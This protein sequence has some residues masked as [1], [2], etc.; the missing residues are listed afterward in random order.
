M[1]TDLHTHTTASDG[2]LTPTELLEAA[3]END[4]S[5]L[6]IT[7]HDTLSGYR[8]AVEQDVPSDLR[9]IPGI[10]LSTRWHTIGVHVL[11]LDVG[12]AS[13]AMRTAEQYQQNARRERAMR[14][15]RRLDKLTVPNLF[16]R[17]A[18]LAG[19]AQIG[20]PH[21]A[22]ILVAEGVVKDAKAA[23]AKYLGAGKLGDIRNGWADLSTV[24]TWIRASGGVA[25]L[26]HPARYGLT[27][28]RLAALIADFA[29]VGGNAIEVLSGAQDPTT[30]QQLA[31]LC[32]R[33]D[34]LASHGSDFHTPGQPWAQLGRMPALPAGLRS[35]STVLNSV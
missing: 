21:F 34:L 14:I 25:V 16:E 3:V 5:L 8:A 19:D 26:A 28:T 1:I 6:A 4:I 20:R 31:R 30:T 7:D 18:E 29:S 11:G 24:V 23:F 9:I 32:A 33:H 2:S 10:E 12:P 35:V 13:E 27:K 22:R 17:A 15:A